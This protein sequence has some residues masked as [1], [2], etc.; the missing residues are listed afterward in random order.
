MRRLVA[1]SVMGMCAAVPAAV[2]AADTEP[3]VGSHL[4]VTAPGFSGE[5]FSGSTRRVE[6]TLLESD[7]EHL[8]IKVAGFDR[9]AVVPRS[10]VQR[11]ELRRRSSQRGKGALIGFVLGTGV[12]FVLFSTAGGDS[13]CSSACSL[14]LGG[15]LF[16]LPAATIGALVAPGAKWED[17]SPGR[18]RLKVEPARGHGVKAAVSVTF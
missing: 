10:S 14:G 3:A 4:R 12:G 13:E 7:D 16:G 8:T 18:V 1:V 2:E 17:L 9:P 5:F 6:G 11:L 15:F